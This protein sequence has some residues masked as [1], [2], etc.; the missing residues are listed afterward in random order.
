MLYR[1]YDVIDGSVVIDGLDIRNLKMSSFRK[2]IGVVPQDTVLFNTT[3]MYN[4]QYAKPD[5][6]PEEV[7]EACRAASIHDRILS[8]PEAYETKVGERGLRLSGGEK[9]R[10]S[11]IAN[12][13][14]VANTGKIAIARA[15]LK[16]PQIILLDE[17]TASLDSQT[18]QQI[19]GALESV[20][21]GRTTIT[22]A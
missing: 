11:Y 18:E 5:A 22:I 2:H 4:L 8:F 7:Y 20:T 14:N 9:Q 13:L 1:F 6:A 15:I 17:A 21:K 16:N 12:P 10:V 19:Q 3:I